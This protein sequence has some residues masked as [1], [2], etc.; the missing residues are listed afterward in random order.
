[1]DNRG[2]IRGYLP[3]YQAIYDISRDAAKQ[4]GFPGEHNGP[5][6]AFRHIVASGEA[7][8]RYG[9]FIASGLGSL[10]ELAGD[11]LKDQPPGERSMDE[12]NNA[13]GIRI[14]LD[15][16][17]FD[18]ILARAR[19]AIEDAMRHDGAGTDGT[20]QWRPESEWKPEAPKPDVQESESEKDSRA[21]TAQRVL[22]QPV[23][24]WTQDDVH[25]VQNS[26]LYLRG[27]GP[28]RSATFAKV[29]QWYERQATNQA[30]AKRGAGSIN[31]QSYVRGD[32]TQVASHMRS[33]PR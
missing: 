30:S 7:A 24:S 28:D 22:A 21:P 16:R 23:D 15:A 1:M 6:D 13:I 4:S 8:R 27:D 9:E 17:D 20:A 29:R 19:A 10:N 2:N 32:G 31:V 5:A 12:A 33:A 14:G 25:A 3:D 11:L 18:E 26:K